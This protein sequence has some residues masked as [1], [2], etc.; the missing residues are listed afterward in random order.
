[1]TYGVEMSIRMV[2]RV[3]RGALAGA[4]FVAY[5]L[6]ALVAAPVFLLPVWSA[7]GFR[8]FIR[9]FY[10]AFVACSRWTGL[11]A[12]SC[13]AATRA[14]LASLHGAVIA[15]NHVSLIDIAVILA[16]I[17]DATAIAKAAVLRNPFLSVVARRMFI[18]NS[19]DGKAVI[20]EAMRHLARGTNVVVFPQGTRGGKTLHRGAAHLALCSHSPL[21]PVRIEY[22]PV[23]LAK[24]Q[25]WWDVGERTVRISLAALPPI[26]PTGEDSHAA[27]RDLT[28][29]LEELLVVSG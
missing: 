24:G 22:S 13:D 15:M 21:Q 8:A 11:F 17:P 19:G 10:R 27:A 18:V 23:V 3:L 1:M 26:Y 9:F 29:R 5:G 2:L 25:A 28:A 7:R 14:A 16:H 6:L 20:A 12:V 4:F